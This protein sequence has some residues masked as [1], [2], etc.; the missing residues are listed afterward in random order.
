MLPKCR[1]QS[2]KPGM[3]PKVSNR[4]SD[5]AYAPGPM[6]HFEQQGAREDQIRLIMF[7]FKKKKAEAYKIYFRKIPIQKAKI[8]MFRVLEERSNERGERISMTKFSG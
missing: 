2:I 5:D 7:L 4:L 6:P 3:G 8:K 1:F